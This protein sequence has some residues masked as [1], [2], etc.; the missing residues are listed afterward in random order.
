MKFA[1]RIAEFSARRRRLVLAATAALTLFFGLGAALPSIWPETFPSLHGVEV[2]TDPENMLSADEPA[3]V[4]HRETKADFGLSDIVVVGVVDDSR[5]EG[6]FHPKA[7]ADIYDLA[8][9]AKTLHWKDENGEDAGVVS[10]DLLAP[11]T[12]DD[13][14]Q[15]GLGSVRF[16]WLM[17]EPPKTTEDALAIRDRAQ[18]IPFLNGTLVSEDGRAIALYVPLTDKHLSYRIATALR[19]RI[20]T[21]AGTEQY[22]ITGLPIAE[23]TFGVE[24]FKQMAISAPLAMLV[25]FLLMLWF[26]RRMALVVGP[27]I[28]AMVSVI[29][30]MGA[31]VMAGK[32]VHIMSSMIPIF[33]M[34]IAV[35]DSVHLLS[36]FFDRY[37]ATGDRLSTMR[38]VIDELFVPMLYTTL[39][40]AAGF[41]SL[42]LTP[43]P[44]VQVFGA[45]VA[46]GI[47]VAWILTVTLI[48]AYVMVLPARVFENFGATHDE[49]SAS[50]LTRALRRVGPMTQRHPKAI[51]GVAAVLLAIAGYGISR[52]VINDNPVKWFAAGHEIRVADEVLNEHFGGTYMAYLSLSAEDRAWDANVF[53][54]RLD[55]RLATRRREL[56]EDGAED[57]AP[58]FDEMRA[59]LPHAVARTKSR[60][61]ALDALD[62]IAQD[63]L[64]AA[65]DALAYS[66]DEVSTA[67]SAERQAD[68][69]FKDPAVL[70]W[71]VGLQ[72]Y[73]GET[74]LVGKSS[75]IADVVQTVHRE[76]FLGEQGQY[77][78]PD[79]SA[80]VAQ[81]L[82]TYQ[83]SHPPDDLWQFVTP[84]YRRVSLWLQLTSGDNRDM[85]A[86]HDAVDAYVAEHAP[87]VPLHHEWF[88][89]THINVV[90]QGKMVVGMLESLAG[91]F[92]VV[93]L[94]MIGLFR[95]VL[96]GLLAM[97]PLTLTIAL[98]YG[99]VGLI[100]KPYDMPVAVLS[101][102]A[103]GLAVDF[104]IHLL[105]RARRVRREV[106]SWDRAL[107][108]M[109][110]EP[111]RAITRNAIV[112]AVGFLP[113]LFAPLVPYQTVGFLL[114]AILAVSGVATL[115][116]LPAVITLLERFLFRG[117]T[118]SVPPTTEE[119]SP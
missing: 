64:D 81:C 37:R 6:V 54:S 72:R 119:V 69:V 109:F 116:L 65:E 75:S 47:L 108:I 63:K 113:L 19:E 71:I 102:L 16:E 25:I 2:D 4:F 88:G 77:R 58:A 59:L 98:V 29:V 68:D 41:A 86:V 82:L 84:D 94:L 36:E 74:G 114:A 78:V 60:A 15:G 112:I 55:Q 21:Y 53:A 32:P 80:A 39:T 79:T 13:I 100:G 12:V 48:P 5:P 62:R 11:S 106:G 8:T 46:F 1:D 44:P 87:P 92:V 27:M 52:I 23:D 70:R 50:M 61:E 18:R 101:S 38:T 24:M 66:W 3:R 85:V 51:L 34:P 49:G 76:L 83:S 96:W 117:E 97:L 105:A 30:T 35:L 26:F 22:H 67:L 91:A 118:K 43:I 57:L 103:L 99:V 73:L 40:S 33:I 10:V 93:V 31:L 110:D 95:S 111:A 9:Y 104:A 42:A 107:P 115:L 28:L 89:L 45:F 7:L 20:A 17:P 90:W 56:V 14:S